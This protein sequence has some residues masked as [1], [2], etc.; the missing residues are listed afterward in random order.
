M[1]DLGEGD[2]LLADKG[3]DSNAIRTKAAEREAW[4]TFHPKPP[5]RAVLS[6]RFGSIDNGTWSKGF[7]TRSSS[8]G[9]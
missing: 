3:F 4:P 6:S 5:A 7:S 2:I 1:E 8:S 9:G